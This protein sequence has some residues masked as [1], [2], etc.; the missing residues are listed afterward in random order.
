MGQAFRIAWYR[1]RST[2]ARQ[3]SG[4]LTVVLLIGL[5]GG[6]GMA[7][8]AGARRTQS[9]YPQF[10]ASTN[11]SDVT[12]FVYSGGSQFPG[13]TSSLTK[14][15]SHLAGVE[16]VVTSIGPQMVP[17]AANGA[18]RLSTLSN[19]FTSGSLD[20]M[21]MTQDRLA[22]VEGRL[23]NPRRA[24]D[25][26]MTAS[27]ARILGVR[28]GQI[29]PLGFYSDAQ[30]NSPDFGSPRVVPR[31]KVKARLVGLVVPNTQVVQD[32]I[33][34]TYGAI[35][36]DQ[37][38]M[39]KL[40][41]LEPGELVPALYGV[42]IDHAHATI[43]QVERELIGV[44]P[45]GATYEFHVTSSVESQVE[46]AIKPES[47]A[48]G[49][50]GTI[51]ALVCLVLAAQAISRL[52]R[53]GEPDRRVLR[54]LGARPA[55]AAF[56]GL[57]GVLIAVALGA[58]L[59]FAVAALLSPFAPLGPVR[60]VFPG[61]RFAID[62]TVLGVG[63]AVLILGLSSIAVAP[64][65]RRSSHRTL[66]TGG[67]FA[68][69]SKVLRGAE[70]TGL[71]V[72]GV[73]GIQF[74][75]ESGQGR[76]AVPV[77][78]VLFGTALAVALVVTTITFASG[79]SNLVSRPPLYGWNWD[80]LL[81]PNNNIPPKAVS[82]LNHDPKI[83][84]WSGADSTDLEIDG[85]EVPILIENERA[86]VAPPILSGHGL[87]NQH[88]IVLG[89][90]TLAM[91]HKHV[92][93]TVVVSLGTKKGA[94]GFIK[95][96]A[97]TIVGTATLPAVGY[98]S[99]IAEHTSMG[100]GAILP[101]GLFPA[102]YVNGGAD[103]NLHGPQLA[104]VRMRSDVSARAGRADLERIARAANNIF[105]ADQN[106]FGNS[107]SVLGVLQPVQ[108]V[109]YRSVGSTPV[110][111]AVGL[112]VGAILALG[113]TLASSVRRRRRDLAMLKTLGF[114]RRQLA[115]VVAWQSTTTALVGVVVGLPVGI[116]VGRELWTLFARSINAVPD[117]TVP[118]W[119]VLIVGV[120]TLVFANIVA[121]LPGR[122]AARTP[123]ALA[124]RAE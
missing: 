64:A 105:A 59:A 34:R 55:A 100:T 28:V 74:A 3:L 73:V 76:T 72:A 37:A 89:A 42:Q 123:A 114:T 30:T 25:I 6:I 31:L 45:R 95:P 48:L 29:V 10:L 124:L 104:F 70:A 13:K 5:I 85:Q 62:W 75:L 120:G 43:T 86:K 87:D 23:A 80:Y 7:A 36:L 106:T 49:A 12:M 92:G 1:Y 24:D 110:I 116:V 41:H 84:A 20:G 33:D 68:G 60:P 15:I 51:A 107:V 21:N 98:S 57:F 63:V 44:V 27:A 115:A 122:S 121:T 71:P 97:L 8:L 78:S 46:L 108:I 117:A 66:L 50:F 61:G 22:V 58:L 47:V 93:E 111:L 90:G 81:L 35:F 56:E 109:N 94:L 32:D 83:M 88:Q 96:T 40:N 54:A 16:R 17:L 9:S 79:L 2:F 91:L 38:L 11:P 4:Y 19:V 101:L 69:R 67:S 112:A 118:V 77:R 119:S 18:P 113:L 103:P 39:Q 26:V 82:L 53:R 102:S 99:Y 65:N 14:S 52:L